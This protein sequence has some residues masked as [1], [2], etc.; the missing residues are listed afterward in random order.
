VGKEHVNVRVGVLGSGVDP[1]GVGRHR[2]LVRAGEDQVSGFTIGSRKVGDGA[3]CLIVGEVAQAHEGSYQL[4]HAYIDAIADAGA[5]AVKFQVHLADA[6]SWPG[7]PWRAFP[8]WGNETRFE[9]WKRMEFTRK[10]WNELSDHARAEG[11]AFITSPFSVEAV[12]MLDGLV[13]AWKVAS[14]EVCNEPMLRAIADT[15]LPVIISTGMTS[16]LEYHSPT[17]MGHPLEFADVAWLQCTSMYPTPADKV[18]LPNMLKLTNY[19][20][21]QPY[22]LSDH[23]G[24]IWPAIGAAMLGASIVEVHVTMSREMPGP[25]TSSSITT[26]E[27]RQLIEG[28]RF[29]EKAKQPVDK[30]AMAKELAPM[31][32]LWMGRRAKRQA[33]QERW[34]Q[35]PQRCSVP[36]CICRGY[37]E[38]PQGQADGVGE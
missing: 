26:Q 1:I 27:L 6:E 20:Q 37:P 31:R 3:P 36:H 17:F 10:Q 23:S 16:M 29:I 13:D 15:R 14:G 30:D 5:D 38:G 19:I 7:E 21:P 9:Y 12:S 25:D 11:L 2:D 33:A 22:G 32:D 18:G 28:V 8:E 4:A 24:T 34:A 35:S